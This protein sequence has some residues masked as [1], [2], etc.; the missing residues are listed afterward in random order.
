M[1]K[2]GFDP[3]GLNKVGKKNSKIIYFSKCANYVAPR[4]NLAQKIDLSG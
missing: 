2:G 1:G 4:A 3:I